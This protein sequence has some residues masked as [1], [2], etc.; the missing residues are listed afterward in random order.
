MPRKPSNELFLLIK[1][2]SKSEWSV[3]WRSYWET[4]YN[5]HKNSKREKR[6]FKLIELMNSMEIYD[7]DLLRNQLGVADK[8]SSGRKYFWALKTEAEGY[9]FDAIRR[10]PENQTP[11]ILVQSISVLIDHLLAR[12]AWEKAAFLLKKYI[13]VARKFECFESEMRMLGQIEFIHGLQMD[14]SVA[15]ALKEVSQR[16]LELIEALM[17][18]YSTRNLREKIRSAIKSVSSQSKEVLIRFLQKSEDRNPDWKSKKSRIFHLDSLR[19]VYVWQREWD[20]IPKVLHAIRDIW[21]SDDHLFENAENFTVGL[22]ARLLEINL[23]VLSHRYDKAANL[24][25]EL[26]GLSIGISGFQKGLIQ[27]AII[28]QDIHMARVRLDLRMMKIGI[29]AALKWY[30]ENQHFQKK[31]KFTSSAYFIAESCFV[32]G[33]YRR[34]VAVIMKIRDPHPSPFRPDLT[35]MSHLL[36]LVIKA[37]QNDMLGLKFELKTSKK[38]FIKNFPEHNLFSSLIGF[39]EGMISTKT[40]ENLRKYMAQHIDSLSALLGRRDFK[41]YADYFDFVLWM[42]S[43]IQNTSFKELVIA[44]SRKSNDN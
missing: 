15:D 31:A 35:A 29:E 17:E 19:M 36:A 26:R 23:N 7:E 30:S 12:G 16:R 1:S 28:I 32:L 34:S 22:N 14:S 38:F 3:I 8:S 20:K 4:Q 11:P 24:L 5:E 25:T 40:D 43:K 33:E 39:F 41:K 18:Y 6:A 21:N 13:L 10:A 9:V 42:R 37:E 27:E 44:Q 2:L